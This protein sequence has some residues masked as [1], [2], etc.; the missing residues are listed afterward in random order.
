MQPFSSQKNGT[1]IEKAQREIEGIY[2]E[3]QNEIR[4]IDEQAEEQRKV[5]R[6]ALQQGIGKHNEFLQSE[7]TQFKQNMEMRRH[8]ANQR[9]DSFVLEM[10]H[11]REFHQGALNKKKEEL[12]AKRA[13]LEQLR[14]MKREQHELQLEEIQR[15]PSHFLD[16][17]TDQSSEDGI[18]ESCFL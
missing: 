10:Q 17:Q 12:R 8:L 9:E 13:E 7:Q 1:F 11:E 5:E 4:Q 3:K 15:N 18:S 2:Q 6:F 14:K 16:N